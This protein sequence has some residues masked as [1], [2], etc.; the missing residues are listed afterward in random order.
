VAQYI[1]GKN[2]V[3][4]R[5]QNEGDI[6]EIYLS[7]QFKDDKILRLIKNRLVKTMGMAALTKIVRNDNH[8]G[9][10]AKIKTFPFYPL[11]QLFL[12][13]KQ[14]KH[15]LLLVLDGV[16]DPHNLGAV[17]R[18]CDAIGVQGVILPKHGSASLNA[19]VARV[20]TGAIEHVKVS[21]ATNLTTTLQRLKKEGYWV[22]GAEADES[23]DYRSVDYRVPIVL[24]MGS[25]GRGI[26]RLVLEQCDFKV[27]LPMVGH[28]GS[29]NV[30]VATA[31]LL[32]QIFAARN[33][34]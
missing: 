33:P 1:Y 23:Q 22:V 31:I 5:L 18:T 11:E 16:E 7:E 3:L 27:S 2:V 6:E 15:P 28:V 20:S 17:L 29:L 13:A 4:S 19:T 34:L 9:V 30:S 14:V 24:V 8:Q 12:D 25:E 26:S 10:V 32:Y 21:E